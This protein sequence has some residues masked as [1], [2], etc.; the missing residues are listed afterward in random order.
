MERSGLQ[1]QITRHIHLPVERDRVE[2]SPAPTSTERPNQTVMARAPGSRHG[3][4]ACH[5]ASAMIAS[6]SKKVIACTAARP[7][8]GPANVNSSVITPLRANSR[9][10]ESRG[11]S[12]KTHAE[13][14]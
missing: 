8:G 6:S 1:H 2:I 10:A 11:R 3:R 4:S 14:S 9:I 5:R 12:A 13:T 7:A